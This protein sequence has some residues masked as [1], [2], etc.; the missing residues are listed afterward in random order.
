MN[1]IDYLKEIYGC[2]NP[3][4]LN[5]IRIGRKSKTAI[6]AE[7]SRA[8]KKGLI[9]RE[10]DGVYYFP[11]NGEFFNGILFEDIIQKRYIKGKNVLPEFEDFDVYGYY[12]GITFL[13]LMG[14]TEQFPMV[15][16]I[17]TN[18]TSS[19]KR[20]I[21]L[22]GQRAILRKGRV[23]INYQNAKILQ[24]LDMF[25]YLDEW[26]IKENKKRIIQYIQEERIGKEIKKYFPLYD[27]E[28]IKKITEGGLLA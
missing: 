1:T 24:F 18:C 3:I 16:E 8:V 28:T 25:R 12:S 4:F 14:L 15:L 17:T 7:L 19:K 5:Q 2:G 22:L 13:N 10:V 21:T 20:E 23:E 6:R 26:E 9:N 11:T 27:F